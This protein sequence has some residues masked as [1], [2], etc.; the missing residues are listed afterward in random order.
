MILAPMVPTGFESIASHEGLYQGVGWKR[1]SRSPSSLFARKVWTARVS[2]I[3]G[4]V[5]EIDISISRSRLT[6][7]PSHASR[8]TPGGSGK[9]TSSTHGGHRSP[10]YLLTVTLPPLHHHGYPQNTCYAIFQA[11]AG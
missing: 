6:L 3:P 10:P 1:Q 9:T 7:T 8:T 2:T 11:W 4:K 5:L